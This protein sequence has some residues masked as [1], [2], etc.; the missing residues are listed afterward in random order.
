MVTLPTQLRCKLWSQYGDET[1]GLVDVIYATSNQAFLNG[2]K[3]SLKI[4]AAILA[5]ILPFAVLEPFLFMIWGGIFLLVLFLIVG[6][7]L[8]YKFSQET[9]TFSKIEAPCPYCKQSSFPLVPYLSPKLKE[10]FS[11]LC[12]QCGQNPAVQLLDSL[13]AELK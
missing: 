11:A 8:H 5:V 13:P 7:A 6:P 1:H 10:Q 2:A 12:S 3:K 4:I 9:R